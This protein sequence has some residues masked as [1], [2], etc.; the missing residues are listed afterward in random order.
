MGVEEYLAIISSGIASIPK[1]NA[2]WFLETSIYCI[3]L[4]TAIYALIRLRT[5]KKIAVNIQ[6]A[7]TGMRENLGNLDNLNDVIYKV[8][9]TNDGLR[10]TNTMVSE[11]DT[12]IHQLNE[13]I[14]DLS[15]KVSMVQSEISS[16]RLDAPRDEALAA[17]NNPII[18]PSRWDWLV[19]FRKRNVQRLENIIQQRTDD[20]FYG[21]AS[22]QS[23]TNPYIN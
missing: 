15:G 23:Y 6:S 8:Q 4:A 9:K 5:I 16:D 20:D 2:L 14:S 19:E 18:G 17:T 13:R 12:I 11:L 3:S 22:R 7:M 10:D 1:I 21:K